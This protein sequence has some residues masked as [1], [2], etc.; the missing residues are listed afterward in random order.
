VQLEYAEVVDAAELEPMTEIDGE[1]LVAVAA[2]V[3]RARLIDNMRVS[4]GSSGVDVDLG[5]VAQE[6]EA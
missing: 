6:S 3:G 1:V 2:Q 5:V 4:V